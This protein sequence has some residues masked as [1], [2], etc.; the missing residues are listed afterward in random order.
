MEINEQKIC[1]INPNLLVPLENYDKDRV[2]W[3]EKKVLDDA[4][5]LTAIA[6]SIEHNLVMD[7]HHRRQV[8]INLGLKLV[9]C[10]FFSYKDIKV[11]SLR[12]NELV[13]PENIINKFR[14]NKEIYP[15]KTA[16]HEL[17]DL[18]IIDPIKLIDLQK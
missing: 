16:K 14:S 17:P 18:G 15:Y 13:S 2:R 1:L 10:L 12:D 3:L 6:V 5:W 11:R 8:A 4:K 7:G 9:P